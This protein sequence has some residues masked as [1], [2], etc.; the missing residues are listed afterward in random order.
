LHLLLPHLLVLLQNQF[1]VPT[2]D[3]SLV[4]AEVTVREQQG[5]L[6]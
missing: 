2:A 1:E 4:H 3:E 6:T 5:V